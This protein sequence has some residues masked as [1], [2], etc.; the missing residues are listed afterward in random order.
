MCVGLMQVLLQLP[1]SNFLFL[2]LLPYLAVCLLRGLLLFFLLA[3]IPAP[4][5]FL[6]TSVHHFLGFALE[7]PQFNT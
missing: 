1:C 3:Y 2:N 6:P 4:T 5:F 7:G